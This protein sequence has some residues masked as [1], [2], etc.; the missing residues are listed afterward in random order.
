MKYTSFKDTEIFSRDSM[1]TINHYGMRYYLEIELSD[2]TKLHTVEKI[3]RAML[4]I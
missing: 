2:V 1:N 4:F 3:R